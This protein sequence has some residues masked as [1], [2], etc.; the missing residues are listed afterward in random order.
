MKKLGYLVIALLVMLGIVLVVV[1]VQPRLLLDLAQRFDER[2]VVDADTL[3]LSYF[4]LVLNTGRATGTYDGH[5]FSAQRLSLQV[6][7][8]EVMT[9]QPFLSI[10]GENILLTLA[11][12]PAVESPEPTPPVEFDPQWFAPLGQIHALEL[13]QVEVLPQQLS[14]SLALERGGPGLRIEGSGQWQ[15]QAFD[16]GLQSAADASDIAL[17][18]SWRQSELSLMVDT[19]AALALTDGHLGVELSDGN[20]RLSGPEPGRHQISQLQGQLLWHYR[21]VGFEVDQL[22]GTYQWQDAEPQAMSLSGRYQSLQ[23]LAE[24]SLSAGLGETTL[25]GQLKLGASPR[26]TVRGEINVEHLSLPLSFTG[27]APPP[28]EE[29]GSAPAAA[30][31]VAVPDNAQAAPLFSDDNIDWRWVDQSDIDLTIDGRRIWFGQAEFDQVLLKV[32]QTEQGLALDP[33]RARRGES[34]VQG[35]MNLTRLAEQ[36]VQADM[37]LDLQG[38]ELSAFGFVPTEQLDGGMTEAKL[39]LTTQGNSALDLASGL[40]GSVL[41]IVEDARIQNGVLDTVASDVMLEALNALNPF[42]KQDPNTEIECALVTFDVE[43]GILKSKRGLVVETKKM[44]IVG[45]GRLVLPSEKIDVSFSP[46]ARAGVGVN[47]G[48]LVKF[49][50]LGGTLRAP[51]PKLDALGVLQSGA[52]VGAA[53][54]TGGISIL[55]EGLAKRAI[56]AGSACQR[57][58]K[59]QSK[60]DAELETETETETASETPST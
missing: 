21:A 7:W 23:T 58:R 33:V 13:R 59:R 26:L 42:R 9:E 20:I 46:S 17:Q 31:E 55:A 10:N 6:A 8:W 28:D 60:A 1:R 12:S 29:A 50:K 16:L 30:D 14:V 19:R 44:E 48:S 3:S 11:P 47:V 5:Q 18:L 15:D 34:G 53:L 45:G 35:R 43:Q 24:L 40:Q 4:P 32:T 27:Q 41:L 39:Q 51:K 22:T 38:I 56:N 2:L 54:S 52:A 37:Q 36:T 25:D 57:A 49:V